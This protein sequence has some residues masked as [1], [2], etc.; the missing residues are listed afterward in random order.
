MEAF[1]YYIAIVLLLIAYMHDCG[2]NLL[3][4]HMQLHHLSW[5]VSEWS[6]TKRKYG[7]IVAYI[8]QF[9]S[10]TCDSCL[11][12][13]EN[14]MSKTGMVHAVWKCTCASLHVSYVYFLW[15]LICTLF[16]HAYVSISCGPGVSLCFYMYIYPS[17]ILCLL[18]VTTIVSWLDIFHY[19]HYIWWWQ[20]NC[21][22]L[23]SVVFTI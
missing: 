17:Y 1:T 21:A 22:Q 9:L 19:F 14:K 3:Q 4:A 8:Y 10:Y 18:P 15:V 12:G 20:L 13:T 5:Q 11:T 2:V 7:K 16:I 23:L 6:R